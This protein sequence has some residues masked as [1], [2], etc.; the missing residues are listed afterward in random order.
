MLDHLGQ[1]EVGD[2]IRKALDRVAQAGEVKTVDMGGEV[3]T[4]EFT[5]ALI[6]ALE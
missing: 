3:G 5:Q 2:R 4:T 1:S 6:S